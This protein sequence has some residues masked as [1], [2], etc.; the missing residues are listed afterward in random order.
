MRLSEVYESIQGEGPRVGT[1]TIF[2]RFAGCN[3]RCPSWPCDTQ[4]AIDPEKYRGEWLTLEPPK[5]LD[6]I[7]EMPHYSSIDNICWTGGEPFLQP[8]DELEDLWYGLNEDHKNIECFSNGT[9]SYPKWATHG[10]A[11]CGPVRFVMDW[12]L[13]GSGELNKGGWWLPKLSRF[14]NTVLAN[15]SAMVDSFGH[16]I[17][18]TVASR[19][20]FNTAQSIWNIYCQHVDAPAV[21]VSPV[22][23]KVDPDELVKW[24]LSSGLPWKLSLQMHNFIFDRN[25]R[26]I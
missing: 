19:D 8:K 18:F 12:K 20:D 3:L 1:P 21:Y 2:V 11:V 15:Y 23:G 13:P 6:K 16:S 5:V 22:W 26:G 4:H 10:G 9:I 17:K 25:D 24:L 14:Q 7:R